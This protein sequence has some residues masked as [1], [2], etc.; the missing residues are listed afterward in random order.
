MDSEKILAIIQS[1]LDKQLTQDITLL[2]I[3][4][5]L[6]SNVA[7][8]DWVGFYIL[9][10]S[11]KNLILGSYVGKPT[12]HVNI[13]VG[14]GVCGQVAESGSTMIVQDVSKMDN[15]IACSLDVQSEI[16]VPVIKNG[17]FVAEIDIDSHAFAP[18]TER[19]EDLLKT[20]AAKISTLF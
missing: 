18:F 11:K 20:I 2:Q 16:V 5:I 6:H 9:D 3:C 10:E 17:R 14:K 19:D 12:E 7:H 15:Y 4:K 13:S 8:Y 1:L